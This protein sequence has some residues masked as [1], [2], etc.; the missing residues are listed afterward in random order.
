MKLEIISVNGEPSFE[1]EVKKKV[2]GINNYLVDHKLYKAFQY[3][4]WDRPE[5]YEKEYA[6]TKTFHGFLVGRGKNSSIECYI[7]V[8][9]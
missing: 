9:Y 2:S 4:C 8:K 3:D 7:K 5:H 6:Q 1:V